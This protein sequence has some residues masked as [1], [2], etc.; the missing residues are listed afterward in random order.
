MSR[1]NLRIAFVLFLLV[2]IIGVL[3]YENFIYEKKPIPNPNVDKIYEE[4]YL[5]D[6]CVCIAR[7]RLAC[8]FAGYELRNDLCWNGNSSTNPINKCSRYNCDGKII[9]YSG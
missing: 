7:G 5:N 3:V 4:N 8:G 1:M 2:A 6:N 9:N